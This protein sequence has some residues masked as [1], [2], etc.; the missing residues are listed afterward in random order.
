MK[1]GIFDCR[2]I[3]FIIPQSTN[4][5]FWS[6]NVIRDDL[7]RTIIKVKENDVNKHH[8]PHTF[9]SIIS[10]NWCE[11]RNILSKTKHK[12][13]K[14]RLRISFHI[15]FV[16][17]LSF[18]VYTFQFLAYSQCAASSNWKVLRTDN[19]LCVCLLFF[20]IFSWNELRSRK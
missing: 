10:F 13:K 6:S 2:N 7:T 12:K 11:A 1:I 9:T 18:C 14:S 16:F 19:M 20:C 15:N 8:Q 17:F 3:R 4:S 5:F